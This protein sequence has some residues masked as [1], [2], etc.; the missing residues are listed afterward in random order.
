M[1]ACGSL[2]SRKAAEHHAEPINE[3]G[4]HVRIVGYKDGGWQVFTDKKKLALLGTQFE[5]MR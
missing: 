3:S 4:G 5:H 2:V 1:Y